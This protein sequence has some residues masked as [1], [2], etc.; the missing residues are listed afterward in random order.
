MDIN[1]DGS[2]SYFGSLFRTLLPPD[3]ASLNGAYKGRFV[4]PRWLRLLAGPSIA[5]GGLGHWWGKEFDG[6]GQGVNV[7]LRQGR[8]ARKLPMQIV[9]APSLL[10]GRTGISIAYA[11]GSPY[12]WP[13]IVDEARSI[14]E[15]TLLCLT[16][17][18]KRGLRRRSFP[19]ILHW[20]LGKK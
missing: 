19:F 9:L 1:Y 14:D 5:V 7:V 13:W 15:K 8:L 11:P 4:G 12:P 10:D 2:L 6:H 18:N 3:V 17:V 20:E 16:F